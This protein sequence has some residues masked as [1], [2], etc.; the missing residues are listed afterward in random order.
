MKASKH[1]STFELDVW[2]ASPPDEREDGEVTDHLATCA[3]C[4]A[5]VAE[6]DAIAATPAVRRPPRWRRALAV[7]GGVL[8]LAA[9]VLLFVRSRPA[10]VDEDA[11]VGVKGVP[12]AQILVRR[13]GQ[14]RVWDGVS[15]V[16]AG[17]AIAVS[18]ACEQFAHVT[19]AAPDVT[20]VWEGQC[21]RTSTL[22]FTLVV[23][24][25][26]GT[27]RFSVVLSP[28]PLDDARLGTALRSSLRSADAWTIDF[29]F[30]KE[31][32]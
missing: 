18:V 17:D 6:L 21:A 23:D 20:R 8:A 4:A 31:E 9:G 1:L 12:A 3:E 13:D 28:K 32:R 15:P 10:P 22:P 24:K 7:T 11:Y 19:V 14:V 5:Y 26:P 30:P 16:R 27:E 25:Q 2:Y 29:A